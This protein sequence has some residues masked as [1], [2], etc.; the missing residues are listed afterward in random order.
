MKNFT[1]NENAK[2]DEMFDDFGSED[3]EGDKEDI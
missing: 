1:Q 2:Y 3:D